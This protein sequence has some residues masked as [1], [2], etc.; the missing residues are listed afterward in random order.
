MCIRDRL[1][2]MSSK[3]LATRRR[4]L[5]AGRRLLEQRGFH[6]VGL[7][8]V[9]RAAGVSRQAVYL[10]FR[11]KTGLLLAMVDDVFATEL[12]PSLMTQWKNAATGRQ[13]LDAAIALHAS[14]EPRV[15]RF[16]RVLHAARREEPAAAAAW[17]NRMSARRSNYKKVAERLARDGALLESWSV[18]EAADLLWALTSFHMFEYLVV[19]AGWSSQRYARDIRIVVERALLKPTRSR[20]SRGISRATR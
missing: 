4:I 2:S 10:H 11:S 6:G 9:A 16:G 20:T 18:K 8:E 7:D 19:D 13:A 12:P 1:Y 3:S 15:Y 5:A 17:N 14:Y